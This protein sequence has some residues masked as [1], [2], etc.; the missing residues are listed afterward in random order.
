[1][2]NCLRYTMLWRWVTLFC[3]MGLWNALQ[4]SHDSSTKFIWL[5]KQSGNIL[6]YTV[7]GPSRTAPAGA[8]GK[9]YGNG[10]LRSLHAFSSHLLCCINE[11]I[12]NVL[13]G[14]ST[15]WNESSCT[16]GMW[17]PC[18]LRTGIWRRRK[19]P[20]LEIRRDYQDNSECWLW[21]WNGAT[22]GHFPR[23]ALLSPVKDQYS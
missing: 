5:K 16:V 12:A 10:N 21:E 11:M 4:C 13:V 19:V 20:C 9:I 14:G 2:L 22:W 23:L 6:Y 8:L 18:R 3:Q 7:H 17:A 15:P 1:M